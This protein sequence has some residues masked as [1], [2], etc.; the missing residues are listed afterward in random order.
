M[1]SYN[2]KN[3]YRKSWTP[4]GNFLVANIEDYN[5]EIGKMSSELKKDG[6]IIGQRLLTSLL[7]A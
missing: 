4:Y 6:F 1:S 7:M 5:I 3:E 2:V